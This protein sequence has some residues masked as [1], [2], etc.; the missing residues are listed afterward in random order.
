MDKKYI[1]YINTDC[2]FCTKATELLDSNGE[3]YSALNLKS[4]AK[5]L[6]ELKAIYEWNTVPMIFYREG[7]NIEFV[8]GFTDLSKRLSDG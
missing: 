4:R 6:R 7:N 2:P 3:N 5:V 8:G 1:L